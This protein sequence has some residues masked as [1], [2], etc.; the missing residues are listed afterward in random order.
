MFRLICLCALVL[1]N[2]AYARADVLGLRFAGDSELTR[3]IVEVSAAETHREM[4]STETGYTVVMELPASEL[5]LDV[6]E[7]LAGGGVRQFRWKD[8]RLYFDLDGPMMIA[9]VLDLPPAGRE[10]NHRIV[11]DLSR[12][13]N[14]RFAATARKDMKKLARLEAAGTGSAAPTILNQPTRIAQPQKLGDRGRTYT[15][16]VD[17]GHG[18]KDPGASHH[19]VVEKEVVLK[20]ALTL[21]QILSKNKRYDV[22]L[23]RETDRF[24][25]LED[26]VKLARDWGADLFISVHADA[27]A[28]ARARGATVYTLSSKGQR[29]SER[30]VSQKKWVLPVETG[31]DEEVTDILGDLVVRETKSN[32]AIFAESLH[33][34]LAEAG[35]LLRSSPRSANFYVLLAPDVP[36]VL[37]EMGFLTNKADARRINS[38]RERKKIMQA[39]AQAIDEFFSRQDLT[40]AANQ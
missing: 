28:N 31:G 6:T 21:K 20:A 40:Y 25:E 36:A 34:E 23:T 35:P 7:G 22:R 16:V 14:A 29:R 27:A 11:M 38:A 15:I 39:T 26:R 2:A 17:A 8:G 9:R 33:E 4:L 13:S 12:V 37:L 3:I 32:S 18:G 30:M 24:I 1:L 10:P 19:G 5:K